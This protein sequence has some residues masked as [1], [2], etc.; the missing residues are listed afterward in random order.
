MG[1]QV[2]TCA[3]F[4]SQGIINAASFAGAFHYGAY[5]FGVF[6]VVVIYKDHILGLANAIRCPKAEAAV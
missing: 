5:F 2:N 6:A 1:E 3:S 4:H